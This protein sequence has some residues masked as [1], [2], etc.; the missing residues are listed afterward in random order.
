MHY[1]KNIKKIK[2]NNILKF[3]PAR[4]SLMYTKELELDYE[5][6]MKILKLIDRND[7]S[8]ILSSG[9]PGDD[10]RELMKYELIIVND[11]KLEL[12]DL[13]RAA[14]E[15][16]VQTIM[17]NLKEKSVLAEPSLVIPG[18]KGKLGRNIILLFLIMILGVLILQQLL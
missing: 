1:I 12:T 15:Q 14:L 8:E 16:G 5:N 7:S 6:Q 3:E 17:E 11:E 10:F 9:Y 4:S 18:T 2:H 13:G